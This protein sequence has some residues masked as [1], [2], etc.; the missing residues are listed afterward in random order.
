MPAH[1]CGI[2]TLKPTAGRIPITGVLDEDGTLG[3]MS[4]PR[5]QPGPMARRVE[6]LATILPILAGPDGMDGG[7]VPVELGDPASVELRGLRVMVHRS[8]GVASPESGIER[9]LRDVA[10][11]LSEAGASAVKWPPAGR[12]RAD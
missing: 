10:L 2:A 6:D 4:D 3:P 11:A 5:T 7:S 8:D 1:F 12:P 9:A